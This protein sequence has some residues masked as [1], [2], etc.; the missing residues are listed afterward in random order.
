M[1]HD[2]TQEVI[3]GECLAADPTR[4]ID[5][6]AACMYKHPFQVVENLDEGPREIG[7]SGEARTRY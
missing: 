4:R 5:R 3:A 2:S 1:Y 6:A 7:L